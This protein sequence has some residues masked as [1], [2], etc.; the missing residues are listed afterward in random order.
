MLLDLFELVLRGRVKRVVSGEEHPIRQQLSISSCLIALLRLVEITMEGQSLKMLV[1]H[2]FHPCKSI[3]YSSSACV[4]TT[5]GKKDLT[6]GHFWTI[7]LLWG[8]P[9]LPPAKLEIKKRDPHED[10]D[11]DREWGS[12][13]YGSELHS[14]VLQLFIL[15]LILGRSKILQTLRTATVAVRTQHVWK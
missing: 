3:C 9:S 13:A 10:A 7:S 6:F 15:Y 8:V 2:S 1:D 12:C 11:T 4:Y 14:G 5:W